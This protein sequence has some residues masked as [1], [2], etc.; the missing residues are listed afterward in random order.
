MFTRTTS[1]FLLE[2]RNDVIAKFLLFLL[3]PLLGFIYSLKRINTKSSFVIF[4]LFS[5]CFGMCFTPK[6]C[7]MYIDGQHYQE[8]FLSSRYINKTTFE[9]KFK[10]YITLNS[11]EKDFYADALSYY[12]SR[13]T[14]NYHIFFFIAS[15][16]FS[17]FLLKTLRYLAVEKE[18][19]NSYICLTLCYL[20]I[21][22]SIFNINGLRFWTGYW[23]AMYALFKIFRENNYRY[24]LLL[25]FA[26]FFHGSL[27]ILLALVLITLITKKYNKIWILLYFVSFFIGHVAFTIIGE[28]TEYLPVFMQNLAKSYTS[29]EAINR[30][31]AEGTGFWIVGKVFG[32]IVDV[33]FF[34]VI[35]IIIGNKEKIISDTR[36]K[37]LFGLLLVLTTFC[38]FVSSV[39]SLGARF[40]MFTYPLIAYIW[41]LCIKDYKKKYTLFFML[42]PLYFFM[43]I[44]QTLRLYIETLN[45]DFFISSPI[46]L[47]AKY[48]LF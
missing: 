10:E 47:S 40:V 14:D 26:T 5:L 48:L 38:N 32:Y 18:F 2:N 1:G 27:W 42:V 24:L 7:S 43:N 3:S 41:L 9:N 21:N 25:I 45:I 29:A 4:F 28:I 15:I 22:I 20:F 8:L 34:V 33:F 36:T 23:V 12:V 31:T 46:Y 37:N 6:K 44:Y 13:V 35:I 39:P 19:D 11:D 30:I 17:F 16:I